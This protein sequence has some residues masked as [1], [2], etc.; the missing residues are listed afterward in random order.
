MT[1]AGNGGRTYFFQNEMPY[2]VPDQ[3]EWM[4]GPGK[5]LTSVSYYKGGTD[6]AHASGLGSKAARNAD[7]GQKRFQPKRELS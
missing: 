4:N 6:D 1:W 2:D 3:N 7:L 5:G